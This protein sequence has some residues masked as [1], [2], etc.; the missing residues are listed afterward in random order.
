M[1]TGYSLY[2]APMLQ[3]YGGWYSGTNGVR[4]ETTVQRGGELLYWCPPI[5]GNVKHQKTHCLTTTTVAEAD[6]ESEEDTPATLIG[7]PIVA[8]FSNPQCN[9]PSEDDDEWVI[10]D[11]ICFDYPA[12][13]ELFESVAN[14]SLHMP[15]HKSSIPSTS[16]ECAEGSVFVT[17]PSKRNQSPIIFGRAQL[18]RSEVTDSSSDSEPPQ[19]FHYARSAQHMMRKM[20]YNLKHGKGLNFEKGRRDFLCNFVPRGKLQIT[21]IT[22]TGGWDTLHLHCQQRFNPKITNQS[23]RT[24][25]LLPN[26]TRMSA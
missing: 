3:V 13:I 26:G 6:S 19:F 25:L 15:L 22:H 11:N 2:S 5:S 23:Y 1:L 21:L 4:W 7:E 9:N 10:N 14:S 16:V 20:G 12:S 8:C 18:R 17:P 24:L